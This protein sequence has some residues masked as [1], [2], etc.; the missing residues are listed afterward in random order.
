MARGGSNGNRM[1][2]S[3]RTTPKRTSGNLTEHSSI[4]Q[5]ARPTLC[6]DFL[7]GHVALSTLHPD[8]DGIGVLSTPPCP[9]TAFHG[10]SL[11]IL[12]ARRDP[13]GSLQANCHDLHRA[14]CRAK[15]QG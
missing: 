12:H 3:V 2:V 6:P 14:A 9:E 10:P 5:M 7:M 1:V 8:D 15:R 11:F 4:G 13:P